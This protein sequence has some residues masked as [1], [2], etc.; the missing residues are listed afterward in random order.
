MAA[1]ALLA[2]LQLS[3]CTELL[4]CRLARFP[5]QPPHHP[6]R[7]L[8][9]LPIC[10]PPCPSVSP[11][12]GLSQI[13]EGRPL[14][15]VGNHSTLALDLGVL[16]EQFLREK[17]VLLRGLAHPVIFYQAFNSGSSSNGSAD[18]TQNGSSAG[19]GSGATGSADELPAWDPSNFFG[20]QLLSGEHTCRL[21]VL[22]KQPSGLV[23]NCGLCH[24]VAISWPSPC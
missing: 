18:G 3:P 4:P 7:L 1:C 6:A 23:S 20:S 22:Q 8:T 21:G 15:L 24:L 13:P 19:A 16:S 5:T 2:V 10:S 11:S 17:G 12:L 14:L 9:T